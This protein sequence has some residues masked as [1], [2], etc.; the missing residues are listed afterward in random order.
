[1]TLQRVAGEAPNVVTVASVVVNA[2]VLNIIADA[3][4]T[5]QAGLGASSMGAIEQG[6]RTVILSGAD[7]AA[8]NF[9]LPVIRGDQVI[10]PDN[11]EI[12]NVLRVDAYT[13][14]YV[15]GVTLTVVGVS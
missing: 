15:G 4:Q 14:R 1:V 7:L 13:R 8:E 3:T 10:L 6:D 12:L 9:P 2:R 11:A 5:A